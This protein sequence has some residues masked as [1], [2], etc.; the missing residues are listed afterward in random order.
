MNSNIDKNLLIY[1]LEA[2]DWNDAQNAHKSMNNLGEKIC[3]KI[4]RHD[5]KFNSLEIPDFDG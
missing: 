3:K 2:G 1:Y 5:T 4:K